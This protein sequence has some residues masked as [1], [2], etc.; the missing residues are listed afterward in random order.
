MYFKENLTTLQNTKLKKK[1][2]EK[3]K[4]HQKTLARGLN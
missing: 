4:D 3:S 2:T 1:H